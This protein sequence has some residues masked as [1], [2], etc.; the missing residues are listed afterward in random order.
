MLAKINRLVRDKDFDN[1]FRKGVSSY[2]KIT[3]VKAVKNDMDKSRFG[4]M[5]SAKI[6]KKAVERNKIKRQIREV[7]RLKLEK[8][9]K[10]YDLVILSL[11]EIKGREYKEIE[12]SVDKHFKKLKL[13]V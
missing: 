11:P 7:I 3:G 6:S 13:Y 1:T 5:V 12:D 4:I 8:I 9:K 2:D 10:G